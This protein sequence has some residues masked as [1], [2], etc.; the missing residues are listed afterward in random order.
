MLPTSATPMWGI[1]VSSDNPDAHAPFV[2]FRDRDAE[3]YRLFLDMVFG[4][5]IS[6]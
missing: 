6:K 4:K 3:Q 1:E 2:E 5:E